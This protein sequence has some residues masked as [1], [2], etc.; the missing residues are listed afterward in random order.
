[1]VHI[2]EVVGSSPSPPIFFHHPDPIGFASAPYNFIWLRF[3]QRLDYFPP[4]RYDCLRYS[5]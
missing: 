5:T 1:M 4:Y 3:A 2:R